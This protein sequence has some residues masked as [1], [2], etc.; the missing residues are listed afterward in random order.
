MGEKIHTLEECSRK[1]EA[2]HALFYVVN[3]S[4][5]KPP[6]FAST[7]KPA[8]PTKSL[9]PFNPPTATLLSTLK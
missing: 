6:P 2:Q 5:F 9:H 3:M 8:T 7:P 4:T 1:H